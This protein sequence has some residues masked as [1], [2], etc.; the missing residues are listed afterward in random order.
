MF[1]RGADPVGNPHGAQISQFEL[2]ELTI[3]VKLDKQILYRAIRSDSFSSNGI[4]PPSYTCCLPALTIRPLTNHPSTLSTP[5]RSPLDPEALALDSAPVNSDKLIHD[6][7]YNISAHPSCQYMFILSKDSV[8]VNSI[9]GRMAAIIKEPQRATD[10]YP[11]ARTSF[12]SCL[13][14]DRQLSIYVMCV[15]QCLKRSS[16]PDV[17]PSLVSGGMPTSSLAASCRGHLGALR[18][19]PV[20]RAQSALGV[21]PALSARRAQWHPLRLHCSA[22]TATN[23]GK[24]AVGELDLD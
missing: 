3:S 24:P 22:T 13:G 4:L 16:Q 9:L 1:G 11:C 19:R 5:Q 20:R 8:P 17:P 21:L 6:T 18:L 23:E 10:T 2:S 7:C 15:P 14:G 12:P